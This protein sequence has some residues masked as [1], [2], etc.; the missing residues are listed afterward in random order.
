MLR[1][2][3]QTT[4]LQYY[5]LTYVLVCLYHEIRWLVYKFKTS[6]AF[7]KWI[8]HHNIG[9][10]WLNLVCFYFS[11]DFCNSVHEK[12]WFAVSFLCNIF[13]L[14]GI[15][16]MLSSQNES[17]RVNSVSIFWMKLWKTSIQSTLKI[18][19]ISSKHHLSPLL[20]FWASY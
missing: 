13:I 19:Q 3:S 2:F 7:L 12:Q 14:L 17:G 16:I 4:L 15:T 20:Y 5:R 18:S 10:I 1:L 9:F 6:L 11:K 8:T